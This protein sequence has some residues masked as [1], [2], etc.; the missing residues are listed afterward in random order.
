MHGQSNTHRPLADGLAPALLQGQLLPWAQVRPV[1]AP[2]SQ[3]ASPVQGQAFIMVPAPQLRLHPAS[4]VHQQV[5]AVS[6]QLNV[7]E[8]VRHFALHVVEPWQARVEP[9]PRET[10]QSLPPPQVTPES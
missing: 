7:Q 3:P 1:T 10:L 2:S 9:A 6:W 8:P 4:A 5:E